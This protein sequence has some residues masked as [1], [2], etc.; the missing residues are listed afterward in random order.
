MEVWDL[1]ASADDHRKNRENPLGWGPDHFGVTIGGDW[2]A[3]VAV[4]LIPIFA[5]LVGVCFAAPLFQYAFAEH[6]SVMT[7]TR[8]VSE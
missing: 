4:G 1:F 7:P 3:L 8:H 2:L 5:G 6:H